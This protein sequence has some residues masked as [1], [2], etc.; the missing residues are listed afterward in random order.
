MSPQGRQVTRNGRSRRSIAIPSICPAPR[1]AGFEPRRWQRCLAILSNRRETPE[2]VQSLPNVTRIS[3]SPNSNRGLELSSTL[4][5]WQTRT[6]DSNTGSDRGR[7]SRTPPGVGSKQRSYY[8]LTD[9]LYNSCRLYLVDGYWLPS[10]TTSWRAR[11]S[12]LEVPK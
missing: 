8:W 6:S 12:Q 2:I 1:L 9:S 5:F 7:Q 3:A 11:S 10:P 4:S